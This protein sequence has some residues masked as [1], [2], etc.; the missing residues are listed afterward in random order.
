[1][2]SGAG[3]TLPLSDDLKRWKVLYLKALESGGS[4]ITKTNVFGSKVY[5]SGGAVAT[6]ALF[7][8]E[9]P[10]RCSGNVF[11]YGGFV[12]AEDF[13]E[14]FRKGTLD[15]LD[16]SKQLIHPGSADKGCQ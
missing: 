5:F 15:P 14:K 4:L 11:D 7:D 6:Y 2:R 3:D 9:G 1:M 8:L 10:L 16:P 12:K 13:V